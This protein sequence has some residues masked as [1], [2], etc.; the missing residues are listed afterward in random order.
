MDMDPLAAPHLPDD[1]RDRHGL[2]LIGRSVA[3]CDQFNS[4]VQMGH[5]FQ[6]AA[7]YNNL[8]IFIGGSY[9]RLYNAPVKMPRM[10]WSNGPNHG[11]GKFHEM[12]LLWKCRGHS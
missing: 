10:R 1:I 5:S 3:I 8:F 2:V 11:H 9:E 7:R 6:M 12:S 4:L